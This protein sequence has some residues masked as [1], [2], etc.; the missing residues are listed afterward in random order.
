LEELAA[1]LEQVRQHYVN[2]LLGSYRTFQVA[3]EQSS[4]EVLLELQRD[5]LFPYRLYRMDITGR[6]NG[7]AKL[8]EVNSSTHLS[9]ELMSFE[10]ISGLFVLVRPVRGGPTQLDS[11]SGFLGG[12]PAG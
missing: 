9:F 4:T 5:T 2:A 6:K 11:F 12:S 8:Q 10:P 3:H 1:L 7:E